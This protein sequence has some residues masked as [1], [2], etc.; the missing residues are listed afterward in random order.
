[1]S[2]TDKFE[3]SARLRYGIAPTR[4]SDPHT[5]A[6]E[7]PYRETGLQRDYLTNSLQAICE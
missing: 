5:R 2:H 6:I 7:H 4:Q 3:A 1:M